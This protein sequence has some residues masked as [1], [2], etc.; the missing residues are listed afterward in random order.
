MLVK[1]GERRGA[2]VKAGRLVWRPQ[3]I[4]D[5][6]QAHRGGRRAGAVVGLAVL[7]QR[8]SQDCAQS[9]H[10][11][12]HFGFDYPA[13][14]T[15]LLGDAMNRVVINIRQSQNLLLTQRKLR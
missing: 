13:G 7:A 10:R 2:R 11:R 3:G 6:V 14:D 5:Q 1:T 15:E 4:S 12:G 9:L 8:G